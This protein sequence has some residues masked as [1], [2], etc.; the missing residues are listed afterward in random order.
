MGSLAPQYLNKKWEEMR[1][2]VRRF[3]RAFPYLLIA[4]SFFVIF[5]VLIMPLGFSIYAS[6]YECRYMNF[7]RFVGLDNFIRVLSNKDYLM[8][9]GIT[10]YV[11]MISLLIS[12]AVGVL[13]AL[14]IHKRKG[15][16]AYIIQLVILIPWVTSQVV[17][18]MLW[19]WI[20]SE[21]LGLLNYFIEQLGG[22][23]L[24]LFSDKTLAVIVLIFVISWRT[25][26][27]AMVNVL[28]GLKGIPIAVEEAAHIDGVNRWQL[29]RYIRF[30]MIKTPLLISTI[31]LTLSNINNLTVPLTLTGGGPGTATNVIT[32]PIYRLGFESFQFGPSSALSLVLFLIT[33][34]FSIIY[35]RAVRYEI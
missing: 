10:F 23:K 14:W 4:P 33:L 20:L 27:Y 17:G 7:T 22:K 28:A 30:P 5:L 34:V 2:Q 24:A 3:D 19:K 25:I 15:I 35:V 31:I 8:S 29:L 18:S 6:V 26:G 32:I 13:M 21:D 1:M 16:Y 9:F 11:S 12:L